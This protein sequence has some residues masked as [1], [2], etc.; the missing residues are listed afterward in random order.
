MLQSVFT[1][2]REQLEQAGLPTPEQSEP[3]EEDPE[4]DDDPDTPK[5][6][7]RGPDKKVKTK[8]LMNKYTGPNGS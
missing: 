7:G 4:D 8:I 2:A 5:K 6:R 1:N 3:E